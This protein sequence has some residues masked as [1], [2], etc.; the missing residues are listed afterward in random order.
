MIGSSDFEAKNGSLMKKTIMGR[1]LLIIWMMNCLIDTSY[2][3]LNS[4]TIS[5]FHNKALYFTRQNNEDIHISKFNPVVVPTHRKSIK[6]FVHWDFDLQTIDK[7][8]NIRQPKIDESKS[9]EEIRQEMTTDTTVEDMKNNPDLII[10]A[11]SLYLNNPGDNEVIQDS[12]SLYE[13]KVKLPDYFPEGDLDMG[14][15]KDEILTMID[16]H[17]HVWSNGSEVR[18]Q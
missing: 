3:W 11:D 4:N 6:L 1:F 18:H 9:F 16:C 14:D 8:E 15:G 10:P 5:L 17:F 12:N 7:E 2:S 13:V